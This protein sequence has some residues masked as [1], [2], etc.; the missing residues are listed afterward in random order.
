MIS[1]R[2][3]R[4]PGAA[5]LM[6]LLSVSLSGCMARAIADSEG[7]SSQSKSAATGVKVT[8]RIR[9]EGTPPERRTIN[10]A[11]D[12]QCAKLHGDKP[13]LDE[14][15]LVSDGGVANA[16]VFVRR[17]APKSNDPPPAKPA[18]LNQ[19]GCMFH[20]RVQGIRVG[21]KLLVG[22]NDPVTHNVRSFPAL[23]QAFNFGQ[24]PA[25]DPRERVF[26]KA[27]REIEVQCDIHPW[28]H[29]YVFV[30][31]H[32]YYSVSSASGG[33]TIEG[34]PPGEYTFEC[35]H[36]KLGRERKTITVSTSPM[37]DVDFSFKPKS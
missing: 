8:G 31:D 23:N 4:A 26:E 25:T 9:Y 14:D 15:L 24:P 13:V 5:W 1:E 11:K 18:E 17:G 16:F 27:E 20:P 6:L 19:K 36:E 29:A 2:S 21:Q 34:L 32:P 35:W 10:T 3:C 12:P 37:A 30:M 22:N 33:Y 28:M 7:S